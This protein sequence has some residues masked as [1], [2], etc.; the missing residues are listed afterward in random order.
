MWTKNYKLDTKHVI[1]GVVVEG[2]RKGEG[3]GLSPNSNRVVRKKWRNFNGDGRIG[4]EWAKS[5]P[6]NNFFLFLKTV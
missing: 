1:Y 4:L 5:S 3:G 6:L 2:M